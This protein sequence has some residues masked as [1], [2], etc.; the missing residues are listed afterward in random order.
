MNDGY[1]Y[2]I[3]DENI[4]Y[5]YDEETRELYSDDLLTIYTSD[6][7]ASSTVYGGE[8]GANARW[9][10]DDEGTLTVSGFGIMHDSFSLSDEDRLKVKKVIIEE[11]IT[12][13]SYGAFY[14][15]TNLETV[16]LPEGLKEIH[17]GAFERCISLKTTTFPSSL[18]KKNSSA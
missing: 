12:R 15:C 6:Y 18:E 14:N 11:G 7:N 4:T 17:S 1:V 2:T 16:L 10:L 8:C 13:I 9:T 3:H 5:T